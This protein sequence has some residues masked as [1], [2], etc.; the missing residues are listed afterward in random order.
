MKKLCIN[1]DK[2]VSHINKEIYGHFS[3]H[4][5]RCIYDGI[6]RNGKVRKDVI[7]ALKE[8][9]IPVLRWPGG[10]FAE[11]YHWRDGIGKKSERP[12]RI[13]CCWGMVEETNEFGTHEFFDLCEELGCEPYLAANMSGGTVW[14]MQSWIEYITFDGNSALANERKKNGREKPWK[15]KYIGVGNENWG[16]GGNMRPEFYGDEYRKYQTFVK[17]YPGNQVLKIACGAGDGDYNWTRK[18]LESIKKTNPYGIS[19]H[20][21]S[22][23]TGDWGK[24]GSATEFP[25]SE[26]YHTIWDAMRTEEMINGHAEVIHSLENENNPIAL[27]V[28]EWGVWCDVEEGTNPAFLYQQN[29]MRDAI[30]AALSLNIFNKHSDIV[31][32]AN[33]AQTVN[34]LQS[35]VLTD[36]DDLVKTPTFY[37]FRMYAPHQDAELLE[38]SLENETENEIE[39][40]THSVSEKDGNIFITLSNASLEKSFEIECSLDGKDINDVI[41]AEILTAEKQAYNSF[42]CKDNVVTK[43][44]SD[45][46]IDNGKLIIN[47]QPVSVISLSV[48]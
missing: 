16:G 12:V 3:E 43:P 7:D 14:E 48:R 47:M 8:I 31:K 42:E 34:V 13:N 28:D 22:L 27:I 37:V 32:M 24:K 26:Y 39:C 6:Y 33:L 11:E 41:N 35:V 46:R 18:V 45:Y 5:G 4:L 29:S 19:L 17:S 9:K 44:F 21:Y 23:P 36:G 2:K 15:L 20:H 25:D 30:V 10:C 38:S 40:L 1:P